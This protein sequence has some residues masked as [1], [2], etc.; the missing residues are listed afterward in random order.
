MEIPK[1]K[2]EQFLKVGEPVY[3]HSSP[4]G[5][6][7]FRTKTCIRGWQEDHSIMLDLPVAENDRPLFLRKEQSCIVRFLHEGEACGFST[8][9]IDWDTSRSATW[10]RVRWPGGV[11]TVG[12]RKHERIETK[13]PCKVTR[14]DSTQLDGHIA[15][16][17][18]GGCC[19]YVPVSVPV[20][21]II[22]IS[23]ELPDGTRVE[24]KRAVVRNCKKRKNEMSVGCQ[25]LDKDTGEDVSYFVSS[26]ID[27]IRT[28]IGQPQKQILVLE[29]KA[30][31]VEGLRM[32]IDALD[33]DVVAPNGIVDCFYRLRMSRPRMLMLS[34]HHEELNCL[35]ICRIIRKTR[36]LESLP[37][38]VYGGPDELKDDA[39]KAGAT[40]Y[41]P[42]ASMIDGLSEFLMAD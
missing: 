24:N 25:F 29:T 8:Q 7:S 32:A 36:G 14:E 20:S 1:D 5:E 6:G 31:I 13:V 34:Y 26:A 28:V 22:M 11:E 38:F 4:N 9:V 27:R 21:S 12:V 37:I 10:M 2:V 17:S 41:L 15:D 30:E 42:S 40:S 23:F 3:F 35:D 16:L 33:Y 19:I 18:A 39:K